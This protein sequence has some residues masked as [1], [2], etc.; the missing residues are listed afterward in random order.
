MIHMIFLAAGSARRFGSDKLTAS[1]QGKPLFQ[2]GL[3]RLQ[4][5]NRERADT[6]L[7]VVARAPQ[8]LQF[9]REKNICAVASPESAEGLSFSIKAAVNSLHSPDARDFL[10]FSAADQPRV[11]ISSLRSLLNEAKENC[12]C[13]C[14]SWQGEPGNPVLFS[15]RLIPELLSLSGDQGG[16][17]VASRYPCALVPAA[18]PDELRDIDRP[19]DLRRMEGIL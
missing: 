12:S 1:F 17:R 4:Q 8:I 16:R 7:R 6:T 5:L 14:L 15:A 11:S 2:H 3:E 18:D 10:L 19:E 13:A 9:C